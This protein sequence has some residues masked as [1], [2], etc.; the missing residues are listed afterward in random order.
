MIV[1]LKTEEQLLSE[2][3]VLTQGSLVKGVEININSGMREYLGTVCNVEL[4]SCNFSM[5]NYVF[6][7][8]ALIEKYEL[9][10]IIHIIK[11]EIG[12]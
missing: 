9:A 7:F 8:A 1:K 10:A 6:P 12:L 11:E 3:W 4:F 2:G 5:D